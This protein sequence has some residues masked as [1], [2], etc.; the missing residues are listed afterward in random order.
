MVNL[1][2]AARAL[3]KREA[4][5]IYGNDETNVQIF[6]ALAD[7]DVLIRSNDVSNDLRNNFILA[8]ALNDRSRVLGFFEARSREFEAKI[9]VTTSSWNSAN[10][11]K[12]EQ[13]VELSELANDLE[14]ARSDLHAA[15][16]QY[17]QAK[18]AYESAETKIG[19]TDETQKRLGLEMEKYTTEQAELDL[20]KQS[21]NFFLHSVDD[22]GVSRNVFAILELETVS[23][24]VCW[25]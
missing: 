20:L 25:S 11:V 9:S 15:Y 12:T 5:D 19:D 24:H 1:S 3:L 17:A 7:L 10:D 8:S 4:P 22:S 14:N 13:S 6:E 21:C 2:L 18:Q 23:A 16:N